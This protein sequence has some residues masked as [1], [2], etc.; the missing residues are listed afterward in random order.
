VLEEAIIAIEIFKLVKMA[1]N[2]SAKID[3][4]SSR[5]RNNES[6]Q[7]DDNASTTTPIRKKIGRSKSL[8]ALDGGNSGW[9]LITPKED[10]EIDQMAIQTDTNEALLFPPPDE[11]SHLAT[12]V[13]SN[14]RKNQIDLDNICTKMG[15]DTGKKSCNGDEY[16][17]GRQSLKSVKFGNNNRNVKQDIILDERDNKKD[18]AYGHYLN[19]SSFEDTP[20][21]HQQRSISLDKSTTNG[22][23]NTDTSYVGHV[24]KGEEQDGFAALHLPEL[25]TAKH[26]LSFTAV[27]TRGHR[28]LSSLI[29][30]ISSGSEDDNDEEIITEIPGDDSSKILQLHSNRRLSLTVD[31][32]TG[33]S[34][35]GRAMQFNR[36]QHVMRRVYS[37]DMM[38][39]QSPRRRRRRALS[40]N[41]DQLRKG[42]LNNVEQLKSKKLA[43]PS[44]RS[45]GDMQKIKS[46]KEKNPEIELDLEGAVVP[47]QQQEEQLSV[48]DDE[49]IKF[50]DRK[51][52]KRYNVEQRS[53]CVSN[54]KQSQDHH[55]YRD[56]VQYRL[57]AITPIELRQRRYRKS[58]N[59]NTGSGEEIDDKK[60]QNGG[61]STDGKC[62][63]CLVSVGTFLTELAIFMMSKCKQNYSVG[64]VNKFLFWTFRKN[65]FVVLLSAACSFYLFT[66]TFAVC[67]YLIGK[68]NHNCIHVNGV[69]FEETKTP[70]VDAFALSWTT[71]STVG[72]GLVYPATSATMPENSNASECTGM[73]IITT[74]EAF[75]GILF[76]GF[77]GAICFAKLTRVSSFAQVSFSDAIIVKYGTGVM[78]M[79]DNGE[80]EEGS[81]DD[82]DPTLLSLNSYKQ[83]KLPYPILEFRIANRLCY[84]KGGEII[85]ACVNIVA[86]MEESH[87]TRTVRNGA[88]MEPRIRRKGRRAKISKHKRLQRDHHHDGRTR[89]EIMKE[90]NVKQA[91]KLAR[92]MVASYILD[93]AKAG[94]SSINLGGVHDNDNEE[95]QN[96]KSSK[97][98]TK[99]F[100][101][102]IFAKLNVESLEHPFFKRVWNIRHVLDVTSPLLKPEAKELI[103]INK[104]HWPEELNN[105]TAVRA[106]I[107]FDRVLVSF[108]GTSNVDANS[109]YSQKAYKF[110]DVCVGYAFCN[111]LFRESDGSIGVDHNLLNDVKEQSGG[112]GEELHLRELEMSSRDLPDIFIL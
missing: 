62:H 96:P 6:S 86:S 57:S 77:W 63:R 32:E 14:V 94:T 38:T 49:S 16:S 109:V 56:E 60:T 35:S 19:T 40:H 82:N 15:N 7:N 74:M 95:Q 80:Y 50:T 53:V 61:I 91:Q 51:R 28:R 52:R 78:G 47:Q 25:S 112:G 102:Q 10:V 83:S 108:S 103:R 64:L 81:S 69:N 18:D 45:V 43:L 89:E 24:W 31:M 23:A 42:F 73:S 59:G 65:F 70:F 33:T 39:A 1:T 9:E 26:K 87:A 22:N 27:T 90:A 76:S 100:P 12:P 93:A 37:T 34:P 4:D 72:Y 88:G 8:A 3:V 71:F 98:N 84:Q 11:A 92:A 30:E 67:I 99:P 5:N 66:V 85:D 55:N 17:L 106:S 68:N 58:L 21:R 13:L 29:S 46:S 2:E 79:V 107:Y 97:R 20:D 101:N 104:G 44:V 48:A 41:I 111:M 75:V 110:E 36:G 105:A 54:D